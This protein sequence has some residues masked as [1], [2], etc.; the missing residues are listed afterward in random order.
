MAQLRSQ[1]IVP[2]RVK[3]KPKDISEIFTFLQPK[4]KVK[5]LVVF[6]RQFAVMVDAGLPL[7]QCL[8]ILGEQ[9]DNPTIKKAIVEVR[10]DVESGATFADSLRKHPKIFDSLY[11]NLVAA[12]EIGGILDTILNRLAVQL[13]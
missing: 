8:Q 13:E 7:V 6:T 3:E 12:G 9:E 1:G 10:A 5:D 2:G 4:V 11:V